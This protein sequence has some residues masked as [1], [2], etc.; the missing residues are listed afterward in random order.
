[1]TA[2]ISTTPAVKS[3]SLTWEHAVYLI[4]LVLSVITRLWAVGE[5][6]LHHDETLHAEYSFSL[7][8][9]LWLCT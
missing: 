1:M 7:F 2:K 3:I 5:R 9:W 4:I 6:A 8:F